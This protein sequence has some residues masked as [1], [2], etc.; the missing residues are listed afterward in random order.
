[1]RKNNEKKRKEELERKDKKM[2]S[3]EWQACTNKLIPS[4]P[5]KVLFSA[6]SKEFF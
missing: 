2:E 3:I 1:M 5:L 4:L 6:K